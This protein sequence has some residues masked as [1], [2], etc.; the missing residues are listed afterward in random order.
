MAK[1]IGSSD[2]PDT[3]EDNDG[4]NAPEDSTQEVREAPAVANAAKELL[5]RADPHSGSGASTPSFVKTAAEVADSAALLDKEDTEPEVTDEE[6]GRTGFRRMSAT[7]IH[8][9]AD[10]A[11]EV[12]DTAKELDS[13]VSPTDNPRQSGADIVQ[14]IPRLEVRPPEYDDMDPY[15]FDEP[16]PSV[17][18]APLFAHECVGMELY[19][20]DD[21]PG[22]P[23]EEHDRQSPDNEEAHNTG[24]EYDDED[25]DLNDP[26]LERFP[27]NREEIIDTVRKLEGGLNEDHS[28]V[29]GLI[30]LSPVVGPSGPQNHDLGGDF[31]VSSPAVASPVVPRGSRLLSLPRRSLGSVSSDWSSALSLDSISEAEEA[32]VDEDPDT[33]PMISTPKPRKHAPDQDVKSPGSDKDDGILMKSGKDKNDKSRKA[34]SSDDSGLTTP[35]GDKPA[36]APVDE[37]EITNSG[38]AP[39]SSAKPDI[40]LVPASESSRAQTPEP[41]GSGPDNGNTEQT[42]GDI[43]EIQA[44]SATTDKDKAKATGVDSGAQS[45]LKR[46]TGPP[47]RVA[48]PNSINEAGMQAAKSGSWFQ[49]FFHMIFVDWIGGFLRRLF[50]GKRET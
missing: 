21:V 36:D 37:H 48:T 27:S 30:P 35:G 7:P 44:R 46:R 3:P 11:A 2:A 23:E 24:A 8:D 19:E 40:K 22:A 15:G 39:A 47:E 13:E 49:S 32:A 28:D 16:L 14:S 41:S 26:T 38:D 20:G 42:A 6:A 4:S 43:E 33:P 1:R 50:G 34:S 12:A 9:V 18:K 45:Q 10:T 29:E 17:T 5:A 31:L 25:I